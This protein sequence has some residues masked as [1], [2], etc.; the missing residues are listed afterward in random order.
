[1]RN[2][3]SILSFVGVLPIFFSVFC[4][5]RYEIINQQKNSLKLKIMTKKNPGYVDLKP[6]IFVYGEE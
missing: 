2:S 4:F 5:Y 3:E 1:M 6:K